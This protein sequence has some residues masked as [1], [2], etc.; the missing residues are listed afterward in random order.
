MSFKK[1]INLDPNTTGNYLIWAEREQYIS[2]VGRFPYS[3]NK[4]EI[5]LTYITLVGLIGVLSTI[6]AIRRWRKD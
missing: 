4:L 2:F 6:F 1:Q 3:I 5:I